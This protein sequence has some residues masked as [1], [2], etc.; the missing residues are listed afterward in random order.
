MRVTE[1]Y[2]DGLGAVDRH[3]WVAF[4]LGFAG[5]RD[6]R[7]SGRNQPRTLLLECR[8]ARASGTILSSQS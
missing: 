1:L 6:Q 8:V 3:P 2:G 4:A 7:L 5:F